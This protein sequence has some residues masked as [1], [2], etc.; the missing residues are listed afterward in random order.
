MKCLPFLFTHLRCLLVSLSTS[1]INKLWRKCQ[2]FE[3][4]AF[5]QNHIFGVDW[6]YCPLCLFVIRKTV[7]LVCEV[8]IILTHLRAS[9]T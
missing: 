4:K 7:P 6:I 9:Y 3:G 5:R 8:D 2:F 1:R